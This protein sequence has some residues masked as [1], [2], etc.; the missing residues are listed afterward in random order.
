MVDASV[1]LSDGRLLAYT[2]LGVPRGPVVMYFHGAPTSRL[3]LAVFE[4][5]FAERGARVVSADRPGYGGSSPQPGRRLEHWPSD[6]AALAGHLGVERF[7]VMALSS[8]GPYAAACAALR[9]E[10]VASAGIV[11]GVTDFGWPGAWSDYSRDEV[12]LMRIGDEARAVAWC[13]ARYGADG[14]GFMEAGLGELPPADHA[15]LED[16]ALATALMTTVGEAFRQGVGGYAQDITLQGRPWSFDAAVVHAPVW[17][18]HGEADTVVP[19][20]HARHTAELIP[21]A[22]LLTWPDEGHISVFT[23][24]P[25]LIADLIAPLR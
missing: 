19:V 15:A 23:K 17:I 20:A 10:R 18:L 21:A 1:A 3:D 14:S 22:R 4:D 6:V 12:T 24:V 13:E 7:A 25:D 8:G 2:D 5:A 9:P 11:A 16:E